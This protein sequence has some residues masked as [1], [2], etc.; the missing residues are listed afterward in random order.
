[1]IRNL[2]KAL[3]LLYAFAVPWEYSL[4]LGE[5]FGNIARILGLLLLLATLLATLESRG[6]RR[7]GPLQWAVLALYLYFCCTAMWTIDL[8]TSLDKVRSYFQA[9]MIVWLMW[10]L[11]SSHR[12]LGARNPLNADL[13]NLNLPNSYLRNLLRAFVAGS[14]ILA[15]L[16]VLNFASPEANVAEQIRFVAFGQD[17]NDVARFLDLALPLGA[18]LFRLE[19]ESHPNRFFRWLGLGFV[20]VGLFAV[21]LTASRGGLI[22]APVALAGSLA[23]V[24]TGHRKQMLRSVLA[25]PLLLALVWIALPESVVARLATLPTELFAGNLNGR[26]N[27]WSAAWQAFTEAPW[28]GFGVGTFVAAAHLAQEDTAHNTPL[29][30]LVTGGLAALMLTGVVLAFAVRSIASMRT[31]ERIAFGSSLLALV[32]TSLV[33]TVE[34]NRITWLLVAMIGLAGRTRNLPQLAPVE[35]APTS[36]SATAFRPNRPLVEADL[37]ADGIADGA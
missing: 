5:P 33:G 20:P 34:E 32:T 8:S 14:W 24:A 35:S 7:P 17:P 13:P 26:V 9:M 4:D 12:D 10:E 30:L 36:P 28:F 27:I 31:P 21:L 2:A 19:N 29:T 11:T 15:L 25:L 3:L 22:A 6:M 16:T 23:I 1:M 18:L 37:D